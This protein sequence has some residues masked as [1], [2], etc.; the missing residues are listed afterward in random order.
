MGLAVFWPD[1]G[2]QPNNAIFFALMFAPT[3]G[4]LAARLFGG[5]RIQWGRPSRW[6]LAGLL[7]AVA[8][9]AVY[10]V[11][12]LGGVDHRGPWNAGIR[13]APRPRCHR[14]S[15][16]LGHR[17]RDRLAWIPVADPS[18]SVGVP[19]DLSRGVR[20][21]VAL[22][23]AAHHPRM[24]RLSGRSTGVH[25][26]S[27]G[28]Q[29]ARRRHHR[30]LA[31]PLAQHRRPR[32]VERPRGDQLRCD[33]GRG[34]R[35]GL[36]RGRQAARRVRLAGCDGDA[37]A[38]SCRDLVAPRARWRWARGVCAPSGPSSDPVAGPHH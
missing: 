37:R 1:V 10:H 11:A 28:V 17:R 22:P 29:S 33:P 27:P 34:R 31:V 26:G 24:V 6:I 32:R 5:G 9:L 4:A 38:R 14:D 15:H 16:A 19:Q 13:A 25:P 8:G 36:R 2:D 20:D 3:I 7:P 12:S 21:L 30:P 18:W 35:A 23:R